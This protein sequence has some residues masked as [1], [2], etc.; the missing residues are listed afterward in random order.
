MGVKKK[1][2]SHNINERPKN[3]LR[4]PQSEGS[5]RNNQALDDARERVWQVVAMIPAGK[6]ATYGQVAA[7]IGL[8]SHARFVG[9]TLSNLPGDTRLPWYRVV[10]ASMRISVRGGGEQR[11]RRLLEAEQV[12]FIGAR[13]AKAHRWEAGLPPHA[14]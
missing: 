5:S 10:N 1:T 4:D 11:Q 2:S 12:T 7:L 13:I 9:R 6:V 3:S 8:P 14:G